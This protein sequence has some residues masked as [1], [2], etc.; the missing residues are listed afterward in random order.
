MELPVYIRH[1]AI[2][3]QHLTSSCQSE[4]PSPSLCCLASTLSS[5]VHT[6]KITI[7]DLIFDL[8]F[9]R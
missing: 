2:L 7:Q 8:G 3:Q 9:I 4:Q 5:C 1:L 6:A